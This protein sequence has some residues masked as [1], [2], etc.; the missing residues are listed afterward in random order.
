MNPG[1]NQAYH[2]RNSPP[3]ARPPLSAST[4]AASAY[5]TTAGPVAGQAGV[6]PNQ[7]KGIPAMNA[8]A[9][10]LPRAHFHQGGVRP[11]GRYP[12][13]THHNGHLIRPNPRGPIAQRHHI[14]GPHGAMGHA[15]GAAANSQLRN[16]SNGGGRGAVPPNRGHAPHH[17]GGNHQ[18]AQKHL[19]HHHGP[20]H[21]FIPMGGAPNAPHYHGTAGARRGVN[22]PHH[23]QA[24]PHPRPEHNF[25]PVPSRNCE[26]SPATT[27]IDYGALRQTPSPPPAPPTTTTTTQDGR[28]TNNESPALVERVVSE[29]SVSPFLNTSNNLLRERQPNQM[30]AKTEAASI[31]LQLGAMVTD[32]SGYIKNTE[33]AQNTAKPTVTTVSPYNDVP[34]T[35]EESHSCD[36]SEVSADYSPDLT[37]APS[38]DSTDSTNTTESDFPAPI[39]ENFPRRLALPYDDSKLNSLHCFL[40]SELLEIFVVEKSQTKSPTHSPRSS[41]GRVGLRCVHCAMARKVREDRDEAPMAVFYPKSI[42]EI[43]RLVTSWQRCHLRKC[44]SLP[45]SV[46]SQWQV[47]RESDKSRGKTHYWVTSAKQIGL[48]DC[49]SRAGGIRFGPN[50]MTSSSPKNEEPTTTAEAATATSAGEDATMEEPMKEVS[51]L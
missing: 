9:G 12:M 3:M 26:S 31:L 36:R 16:I 21:R 10:G 24:Q 4:S 29:D 45:P 35:I 25:Q 38:N 13:P 47:L 48:V 33:G 1:Q 28:E 11:M 27:S 39:P 42:A 40:R 34:A 32:S 37:S 20:H 19:V 43:Y 51:A 49:I 8:A 50:T 23:G 18:M 5:N 7:N 6:N 22:Y 17:F 14:M 2:H 30:E 41:V 15:Q 44:R 46:R